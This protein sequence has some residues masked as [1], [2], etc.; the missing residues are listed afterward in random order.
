MEQYKIRILPAAQQDMR[1]IINYVNTLSPEAAFHLYD[2]TI[3]GI[4]SLSEM[5]MRCALL[6]TPELRAKGYRALRIKN[7]VIFFVLKGDSVQIRR[8]LYAKR[9]YKFL[10]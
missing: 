8:I 10:L 6:R 9:Q 7:Y 3:E 2:E 5:P 4:K 1:E